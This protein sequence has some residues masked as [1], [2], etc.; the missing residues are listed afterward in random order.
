VRTHIARRKYEADLPPK[1]IGQICSTA[2]LT[3]NLDQCQNL[4]RRAS[5]AGA[6]ALFL[7]EASDYIA[8]SA[9][10]SVSL[11]Q[12]LQSSP[13]VKGIQA[14]AKQ[15]RLAINVGVHEPTGDGR[16][17]RN[18]LLWIDDQGE[19]VKKYWKVHLFDVDI[20]DGPTL[21]ESESVMFLG[22]PE[23]LNG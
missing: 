8:S 4:A 13:F 14:A 7:P 3:A 15:H 22:W 17:L 10:E 6:S 9:A 12:P 2:D 23:L 20:K 18:S 1:A 21:R 11:A 19:I 5:A 16:R